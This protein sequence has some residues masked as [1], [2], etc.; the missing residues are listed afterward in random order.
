MV[1]PQSCGIAAQQSGP[2]CELMLDRHA[3]AGAAVQNRIATNI[4][5]ALLLRKFIYGA[6]LPLQESSNSVPAHSDLHHL[7]RFL[8]A[9]VGTDAANG[10]ASAHGYYLDVSG[11]AKDV[12][13]DGV[14]VALAGEVDAPTADAEVADADVLE[15]LRQG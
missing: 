14:G 8:V 7:R 15:F 3:E 11:T 2:E 6:R 1:V 10:V 4:N 5:N 13:A 12:D 9:L